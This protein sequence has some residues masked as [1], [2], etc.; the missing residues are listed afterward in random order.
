MRRVLCFLPVW[1]WCLG[2]ELVV[3]KEG[4][5]DF[6]ELPAAIEAA[7][8]G[9]TVVVQPGTYEIDR[10]IVFAGKNIVLRAPEGP[11][12]TTIRMADPPHNER[13]GAILIFRNGETL[14]TVV[15]GF[16]LTGGKGTFYNNDPLGKAGGAILCY[17]R[18]SPTIRNCVLSGNEAIMGGAVCIDNSQPEFFDCIIEQNKTSYDG[19]ALFCFSNAEAVFTNCVFREN[20]AGR[21]G[22]AVTNFVN[23]RLRFIEC[24]FTRNRCTELGG[25]LTF[26]ANSNPY[27]YRCLITNNYSPTFGG[28]ILLYRGSSP[29]LDCCI[30]AGNYAA[31]ESGGALACDVDCAPVFNNCLIYANRAK[32]GGVG[33]CIRSS[34]PVFNH[35]TVVGNQSDSGDLVLC[36]ATSSHPR[37]NNTILWGNTPRGAFCGRRTSCLEGHDPRFTSEGDFD[38]R[39]FVAVVLA[40]VKKSL[41]D[42]IQEEPDFHLQ[43]DS[44]AIDVGS[45]VVQLEQDFEGVTRPQGESADAGAFEFSGEIPTTAV[46]SGDING[47]ASLNLAD[48]IALLAYIFGDGPAPQCLAGAEVNNDGAIDIADALGVLTYL[49]A[50]GAVIG[51]DGEE[52]PSGSAGCREYPT[53][54]LTLSCEQPCSP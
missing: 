35:C 32:K 38:R 46:F 39:N 53:S 3:D 24:T 5:G 30:L 41:P 1:A 12:Q 26:D 50:G 19:G 28:G 27:F 8:D 49:F 25:G 18:S 52:I 43:A 21:H 9:D 11:D 14:S 22:G 15:E 20:R 42:F 17:N 51:P 31:R 2:A 34:S 44:P 16:T 47:D 33:V 45:S 4:T 40:G 23:C 6:T 29:T 13:D 37:Y 10:P 36:T 54:L 48:A 7:V